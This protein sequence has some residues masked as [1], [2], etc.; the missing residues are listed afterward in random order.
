MMVPANT[1]RLPA[2]GR[3]LKAALDAGLRP[4][5]G[6]GCIIVTSEW[7]YA[8]AFDPG[9]VVCPVSE[10]P[11]SYDFTFLNGCE[12]IVLV[13]ECDEVHG[14]ALLAKVKDARASVATLHLVRQ[15]ALC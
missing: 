14:E 13:H 6:G 5:K 9:R 4:R 11:D 1:P 8:R 10:S 7:E 2:Y 12:A 15:R 3:Q